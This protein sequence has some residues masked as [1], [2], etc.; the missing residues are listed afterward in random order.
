MNNNGSDN[1][2]Q[3]NLIGGLGNQL[4]QVA[5]AKALSV[6]Y[7]LPMVVNESAY[8]TYKIRSYSLNNI[9]ISETF[10]SNYSISK[11]R[12]IY[13]K[14]Y[15]I[16]QKILKLIGVGNYG[17]LF[18]DTFAKRGY[19]YN[20]DDY[21]YEIDINSDAKIL[22]LYG[23]FQSEKYFEEFRGIIKK[24]LK[25]NQEPTNCEQYYLDLISKHPNNVAISMR[26]GSDYTKSKMFNVCTTNYYIESIKLA[27]STLGNDLFLVFSD[28]I[29]RA[30]SILDGL[31]DTKDE[32]VIFVE[33]LR[34][35][36]SLR[37]MY[38]CSNF[39]ISNSSFAWWGAYLSDNE[40]K[41]IISPSRWYNSNRKPPD[42][43]LDSFI[44]VD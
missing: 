9:K 28:D 35:Y 6:K 37:V 17:K 5:Y 34:D 22:D 27:K 4:F 25:V 38:S 10:V 33:G 43:L 23:Y 31:D 14:L 30:K 18:I 40:K 21:F 39:I 29:E 44:N 20:F 41:I 26:L 15:R 24:E 2:I 42:I 13:R 36:Q 32:R 12:T 11:K 19:I 3:I 1:Y 7:G 8:E 16:Y